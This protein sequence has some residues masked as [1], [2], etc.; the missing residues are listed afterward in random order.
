MMKTKTSEEIFNIINKESKIWKDHRQT[1]RE[2]LIVAN[3]KWVAVDDVMYLI[4]EI[5]DKSGVRGAWQI[6]FKEELTQKLN[7]IE[8]KKSQKSRK[9][10][11]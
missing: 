6:L 10:T 8:A 2:Y 3:K 4:E 5:G 9:G 1:M 11:P 7:S